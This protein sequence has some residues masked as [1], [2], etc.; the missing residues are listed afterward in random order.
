MT[1]HPQDVE[2]LGQAGDVRSASQD[3]VPSAEMIQVGLRVFALWEDSEDYHRENLVSE[4][5]RQMRLSM[6]RHRR[7]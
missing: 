4:I 5:Y 1:K 6:A 3:A 7:S 2:G